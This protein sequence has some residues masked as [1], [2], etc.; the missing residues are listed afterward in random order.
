[1]AMP[2]TPH[3][4]APAS[5]VI[6]YTSYLPAAAP[7]P[8]VAYTSHLPTVTTPALEVAQPSATTTITLFPEEV[9]QLLKVANAE[10]Y[11]II[12]TKDAVLIGGDL[13]TCMNSDCVSK[14]F[15]GRH[16]ACG[17]SGYNEGQKFCVESL[18]FS[19]QYIQEVLS[20]GHPS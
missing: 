2:P 5:N 9:K 18:F 19:L 12:V 8:G 7:V 6:T 10:V 3:H 16:C 15:N 14:T 11:C 20:M 13:T 1:M 17:G 4:S